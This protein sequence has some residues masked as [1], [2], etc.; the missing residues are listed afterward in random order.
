[1]KDGNIWLYNKSG[2]R[3]FREILTEINREKLLSRMALKRQY[4]VPIYQARQT[5]PPYLSIKLP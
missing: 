2:S 3:P 1:M 5:I 4:I